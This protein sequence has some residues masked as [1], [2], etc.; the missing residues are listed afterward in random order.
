[1]FC[2]LNVCLLRQTYH[3][4]STYH[5]CKANISRYRKITYHCLTIRSN[6]YISFINLSGSMPL[7][8][9]GDRKNCL[10]WTN[11][12]RRCMRYIERLNSFKMQG[13][14]FHKFDLS[15]L[16][17]I[18]KEN[19]FAFSKMF[20]LRGPDDFYISFIYISGSMSLI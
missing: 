20:S 3:V 8:L 1:M 17:L 7:K 10:D 11:L 4:Q 14:K 19:A 18:K 6:L 12:T 5:I 2:V 13:I 16:Y 15:N 9:I